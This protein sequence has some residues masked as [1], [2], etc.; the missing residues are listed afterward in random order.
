MS[1]TITAASPDIAETLYT[2]KRRQGLARLAVLGQQSDRTS[3]LR[4][5]DSIGGILLA[6]YLYWRGQ[7]LAGSLVLTIG[8]SIFTGLVYRHQRLKALILEQQCLVKI[9]EDSL[10]RLDGSWSAFP[11]TGEEFRDDSHPYTS[12]LDI[13]GDNSLFQ[14]INTSHSFLGRQ[15]LQ[16]ALAKPLENSQVIT[17]R[18]EAIQELAEKMDWRQEF[19]AAGIIS[20][21]AAADPAALIQWAETGNEF[22]LQK[23]IKLISRLL[24]AISALVTLLAFLWPDQVT[25]LPPLALYAVQTAL[26]F[27]R[28]RD[29][30]SPFAIAHQYKENIKTFYQMLQIMDKTSWSAPQL[31]TMSAALVNK[32]GLPACRQIKKLDQAVD[33]TYMRYSQLY[34][35]FNIITLWDFQCQIALAAW[36]EKSGHDL[37]NWCQ[38]IGEVELLS[39]L[40]LLNFD[41]PQWAVPEIEPRQTGFTAQDLA[42]PLLSGKKVGNDLSL[43]Q[44]GE[45]FLITGSNMSGKSTLLRTVG[46]NLVLAGAGAPVCATTYSCGL[47]DI[48]TSMRTNDNLA[49]NTSSFYAELLRI[50]EI[51]AIAQKKNRPLFFLLDEVFKGTNSLDRHTGAKYLLKMLSRTGA[52]GLVSTHDLELGS[53]ADTENSLI[54]NYHFTEHYLDGQ[55]VFDYTLRPGISTT[56]N[57]I[58]LMKLAGI[59]IE[60]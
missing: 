7:S 32:A 59:E 44:P 28:R 42:H 52:V 10:R 20:G 6:V 40:A 16:A 54:R 30:A 46:I 58:Y 21:V 51:L 57:A 15:K 9:N 17:A 55:L 34:F 53:L 45:I 18:Q 27:W 8:T 11:D 35:I 25:Y 33:M 49:S 5:L 36:K 23:G 50:K 14:L 1:S 26:L 2:E 38:V 3:Q 29:I 13:F 31:K 22:Y 41:H 37:Q 43:T 48:F 24:P 56:R 47:M 12:D 4:L 60:E 39:S 19:Q